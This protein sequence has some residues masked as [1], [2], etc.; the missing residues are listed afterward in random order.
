MSTISVDRVSVVAVTAVLTVALTSMAFAGCCE[1]AV[2]MVYAGGCGGCG[3]VIYVSPS[4]YTGRTY[5]TGFTDGPYGDQANDT[6]LRPY[7]AHPVFRRPSILGMH[8][9]VRPSEA[10]FRIYRHMVKKSAE[11]YNRHTDRRIIRGL[12]LAKPSKPLVRDASAAGAMPGAATLLPNSGRPPN[13][14][15]IIETPV[16][17][18]VKVAGQKLQVISA[19]ANAIDSA[20]DAIKLPSFGKLKRNDSE[21]NDLKQADAKLTNTEQPDAV[22]TAAGRAPEQSARGVAVA[23][24]TLPEQTLAAI[25]GALAAVWVAWF[26]ILSTP[27]KMLWLR[28][29]IGETDRAT[30][31]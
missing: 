5:Y 23:S 3:H 17:E 30:Q 15:S 7:Y 1:S 19:D 14:S 18:A 25:A 24:P 4:P 11:P 13:E 27:V 22:D 31:H 28:P 9:Y 26:L 10:S 8:R 12:K 29:R 21:E 2:P 6:A 20:S 16:P